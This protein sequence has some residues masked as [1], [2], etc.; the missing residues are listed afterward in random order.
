MFG[1]GIC[2]GCKSSDF[3]KGPDAESSTRKICS[4]TLYARHYCTT[5]VANHQS[6]RMRLLTQLPNLL[7]LLNLFAGCVALV[8]AFS[9]GP[10]DY[11]YPFLFVSIGIL[12]DFFDGFL[13][14]MF[15]VSSEL[16]VQLDSLADMVTSGVVP[17]LIIFRMLDAQA[18]ED[19]GLPWW[20]KYAAFLIT[21]ASCWRLANFN[22]DTRQ[23][24][25]FI[26]LPTPA[27][28]LMITSLPI[29]KFEGSLLW[30]ELL[31]T[32]W[33]LFVVILFSSFMLNAE[34]PLFSLKIKKK[35]IGNYLLPI[36]FLLFALLVLLLFG[37]KATPAIILGYI[38]A[39]VISN[40]FRRNGDTQAKHPG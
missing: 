19:M 31:L 13:A 28:T 1:P 36:G 9:F 29:L 37:F 12:F 18:L 40:V 6:F 39:S 7:T 21:L 4:K 30:F 8:F 15:K 22:I 17:G 20:M 16:G 10:G 5:F 14:R 34:I 26:G 24:D 38:L 32:P 35:G 27:N 3:S 25:S 23:T 11:W 33:V 2:P